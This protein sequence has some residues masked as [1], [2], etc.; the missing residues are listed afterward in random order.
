MPRLIDEGGARGVHESASGRRFYT[1]RGGE[2]VELCPAGYNDPQA[3]CD[4]RNRE[5]GRDDV[6]WIV[7]DGRPALADRPEWTEKHGKDM[8]RRAEQERADWK[9]RHRYPATAQGERDHV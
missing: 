9:H 2:Q 4:W 7:Q 8:A 5:M 1:K 3:Y 6:M